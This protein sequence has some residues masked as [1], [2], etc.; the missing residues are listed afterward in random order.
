[1]SGTNSSTKPRVTGKLTPCLLSEWEVG[2]VL[3]RIL[4]NLF[5]GHHPSRLLG[6]TIT[7]GLSA[8]TAE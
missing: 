4:T 1:M 5:K 6:N 2:Y 7:D 8:G 3:E